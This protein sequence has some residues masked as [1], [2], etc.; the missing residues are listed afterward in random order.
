MLEIDLGVD[1]S[2]A[3]SVQEVGD[4]REWVFIFFVILLSP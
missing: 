2:M 1:F 3:Q 4:V